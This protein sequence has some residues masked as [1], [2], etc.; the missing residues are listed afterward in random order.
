MAGHGGRA[1]GL[2]GL[3]TETRHARGVDVGFAHGA[4]PVTFSPRRTARKGPQ[5]A[6]ATG[7][8]PTGGVISDNA[9]TGCCATAGPRCSAPIALFA[10]Q[11]NSAS[12]SL[13]VCARVCGVRV[14]AWVMG[15][16]GVRES[17]YASSVHV[18]AAVGAYPIAVTPACT[19]TRQQMCE[20]RGYTII[21]EAW[22]RE[23]WRWRDRKSGNDCTPAT[24]SNGSTKAVVSEIHPPAPDCQARGGGEMLCV[25]A[26][27]S[28]S[29]EMLQAQGSSPHHRKEACGHPVLSESLA[30]S[31]HPSC[32]I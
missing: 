30:R 4:G 22:R 3:T 26:C 9:A 5:K 20:S 19:Y 16:R 2:E 28:I 17:T 25:D 23:S 12:Q 18:C 11:S 15:W 27:T 7:K 29:E 21:D 14:R 1:G 13:S 24:A 6:A 32:S 31:P 10:A 8:T